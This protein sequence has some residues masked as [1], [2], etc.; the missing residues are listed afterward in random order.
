MIK[1]LNGTIA[2]DLKVV[3]WYVDTSFVVYPFFKSHTGEVIN[4]TGISAVSF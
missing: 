4:G 3:K 1:Y 2:Y